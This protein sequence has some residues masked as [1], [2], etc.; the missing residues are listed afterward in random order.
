MWKNKTVGIFV[1]LVLIILGSVYFVINNFP[2]EKEN[3]NLGKKKQQ[4]QTW[5][6]Y[7]ENTSVRI[8]V[9]ENK[10]Q[11]KESMI[12][13]AQMW[14]GQNPAE[15]MNFTGKVVKL[16]ISPKDKIK[17][18]AEK[19]AQEFSLGG[20]PQEAKINYFKIQ[21]KTAYVL[22]NIDQD[23]YAGVSVAI[24]TIHPVV[25]KTLLQ[26]DQIEKVVFSKAPNDQ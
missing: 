9:P 15:T 26:F 18:S 25:K 8:V 7:S 6:T 3:K 23:G 20:G 5:K 10:K 19:A 16:E 4:V 13:Y 21:D 17:T 1:F 11:Y 22:L 2:G 14:K 24:A 12:K